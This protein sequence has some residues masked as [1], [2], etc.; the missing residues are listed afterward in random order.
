M[1]IKYAF[2]QYAYQFSFL[3]YY[4][5]RD[6]LFYKY[7]SNNKMNFLHFLT[8]S[9]DEFFYFWKS[10]IKQLIKDFFEVILTSVTKEDISLVIHLHRIKTIEGIT[11]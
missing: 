2:E 11:Q 4:L 7:L 1:T 3:E 6:E 10:P 5:L 9:S 8:N